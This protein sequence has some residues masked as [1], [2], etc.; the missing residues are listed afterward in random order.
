MVKQI[1]LEQAE[2]CEWQSQS[3]DVS[4]E[5][6]KTALLAWSKYVGGDCSVFIMVWMRS[7]AYGYL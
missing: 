6:C 7:N 5:S 1:M 4:W 3:A 2:L